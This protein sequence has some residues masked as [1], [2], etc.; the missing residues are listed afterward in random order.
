MSSQYILQLQIVNSSYTL[1]SSGK[2][3]W[4]FDINYTWNTARE[5]WL[6]LWGQE[7]QQMFI[8][9]QTTNGI[10]TNITEIN[11]KLNF[12]SGT[13]PFT[14]TG[15]SLLPNDT[16]QVSITVLRDSNKVPIS[17]GASKQETLVIQPIEVTPNTSWITTNFINMKY[18]NFDLSGS[19]SA[20][21]TANFDSSHNNMPHTLFLQAKTSSNAS[22]FVKQFPFTF[23]TGMSFTQGI[24]EV[25]TQTRDPVINLS[26]YVFDSQQRAYSLVNLLT[27]T[28]IPDV[29][30]PPVIPIISPEAQGILNKIASGVI[31]YPSYFNFNIDGVKSGTI[32]SLEFV[33]AYNY[34]KSTGVIIDNTIVIPPQPISYC[35]N[36][37][38]INQ[39]GTVSSVHIDPIYLADYQKLLSDGKMVYRCEDNI[40]P[41][42][43]QVRE[44]YGYVT[45]IVDKIDTTMVSQSIGS[46]VLLNGRVKGEILYIANTS[47]NSAFYNK[48][49]VSLVQIKS[50]TGTIIKIKENNLNFTLTER[51]ER[52]QIDQAVEPY[53]KIIIE[54]YVW[55]ALT[56]SRA[57]SET[58]I[59]QVVEGDP[60]ACPIGYHKD[61]TGKCVPNDPVGAIPRD[62]LIDTLKGFLFGT[63]A[64]SLLARKY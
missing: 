43:Q 14:L 57:F 13:E 12:P 35:V 58:K 41:S 7:T 24:N 37:Y 32:T 49:I 28:N 17:Y 50:E 27:L 15:S 40:I 51:D 33:N 45:P 54:F 19:I 20:I 38:S 47:F 62:K 16:M 60:E 46:F 31:S 8:Q 6:P 5:T 1:D 4:K 53:K 39:V 56:D 2:K 29:V 11:K 59:I 18:K 64:L 10:V 21:K 3:I 25:I 22:L 30:I 61:F 63:V 34:L 9:T 36:V 52:I 42:E 44:H 26:M 55:K 48:P 23:G